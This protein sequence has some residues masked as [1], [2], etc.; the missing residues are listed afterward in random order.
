MKIKKRKPPCSSNFF[1]CGA[2]THRMYF[3]GSPVCASNFSKNENFS[4]W[5][6]FLTNGS[7]FN[8]EIVTC[9]FIFHS[10]ARFQLLALCI[11]V[12]KSYGP[13]QA[14]L[15]AVSLIVQSLSKDQFF[16]WR[17]YKVSLHRPL[18]GS[19]H[20]ILF[21]IELLFYMDLHIDC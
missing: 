18:P 14:E 15:H 9:R 13:K 21:N 2:C 8:G 3:K 5:P 4:Y 7:A 11:G 20:S 12:E 17:M 16:L 1:P 19:H 6:G 10:G